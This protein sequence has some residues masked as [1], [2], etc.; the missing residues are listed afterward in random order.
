MYQGQD[1]G[2]QTPT[3]VMLPPRWAVSVKS[4]DFEFTPNLV[5]GP[6]VPGTGHGHIYLNGLNGIVQDVHEHLVEAVELALDHGEF[7]VVA[8]HFDLVF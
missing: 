7:S 3:M 5:D 4:E 1:E 6:H 8:M 2:V